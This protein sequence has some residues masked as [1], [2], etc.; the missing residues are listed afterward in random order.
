MAFMYNKIVTRR[1][2]LFKPCLYST[3]SM[4]QLYKYMAFYNLSPSK[5]KSIEAN[6]IFYSM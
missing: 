4:V 5:L 2:K 3:H 6:F 1:N